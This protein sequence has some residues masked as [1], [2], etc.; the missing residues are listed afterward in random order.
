MTHTRSRQSPCLF[1]VVLVWCAAAPRSSTAQE[2]SPA[3]SPEAREI[4]QLDEQA[5]AALLADHYDEGI[6][7]LKKE[8]EVAERI[9][10]EQ[11]REAVA[12]IRVEAQ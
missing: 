10:G 3:D 7:A 9:R 8:L 4:A 6:A 5:K 2:L 1:A 12:R 11:N